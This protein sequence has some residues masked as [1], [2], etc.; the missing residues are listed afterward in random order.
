M[1]I[2]ASKGASSNISNLCTV[3]TSNLTGTMCPVKDVSSFEKLV[4]VS[5]L[6]DACSNVDPLKECCRPACGPAMMEAAMK[7][8][9][10]GGGSGFLGNDFAGSG[11]AGIDLVSDC[12]GVVYAWLAKKLS[13]ETANSAF[14]MM[15]GCKVNKGTL[16]LSLLRVH[17]RPSGGPN[18]HFYYLTIPKFTLTLL[19]QNPNFK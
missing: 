18:A 12:K 2:L 14:R 10:Q 5:K 1:N 17:A 11:N 3:A 15:T 13:P 6:L 9:V 19:V 8:S 7:I 16:S 4:N